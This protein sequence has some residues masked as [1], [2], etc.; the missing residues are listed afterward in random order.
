MFAFDRDLRVVLW[1]DEAERLTGFPAAEVLGSYC[2]EVLDGVDEQGNRVCRPDCGYAR[3]M[4]RGES[5]RGP[6][7]RIRTSSGARRRVAFSLLTIQ[8]RQQQRYL[9]L[10]HPAGAWA[11]SSD[12]GATELTPRQLDVLRLAADGL[13]ARAIGAA[14]G[15]AETTVR[16][17][18]N[19]V[20]FKLDVETREAAVARARELGII[21]PSAPANSV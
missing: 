20:R 14:L 6:V 11:A 15:L 17:H 12:P 8:G 9:H 2:W 19:L 4:L 16:N 10:V 13:S 18:L 3:M 21:A 1:N 5:P 7:V